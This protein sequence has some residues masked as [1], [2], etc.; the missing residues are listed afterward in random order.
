MCVVFLAVETE[1][2]SELDSTFY[3]EVSSQISEVL[4]H[5]AGLEVEA[6]APLT[7]AQQ[8]QRR[9][10]EKEQKRIWLKKQAAKKLGLKSVDSFMKLHHFASH[11]PAATPTPT[12]IPGSVDTDFPSMI[13][14]PSQR[15]CLASNGGT[16]NDRLALE[17]CHRAKAAIA[18]VYDPLTD[19]LRSVGA[20]GKCLDASRET[21][22]LVQY[23]CALPADGPSFREQQF[24]WNKTFGAFENN[25][26]CMTVSTNGKPAA[27]MA[28]CA[29]TAPK[30]HF[31]AIRKPKAAAKQ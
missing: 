26:L 27:V 19:Q 9:A 25:G 15:R 6:E 29:A 24:K 8:A 5:D 28:P 16:T 13:T 21:G 14:F 30:M 17:R 12:P 2:S 7:K 1:T 18:W 20:K 22:T 31:R 4:E 3:L 10:F 11:L 23:K